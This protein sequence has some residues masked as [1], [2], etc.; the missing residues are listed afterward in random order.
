MT[1]SRQI[2]LTLPHSKLHSQEQILVSTHTWS[3]SRLMIYYYYLPY[4]KILTK[5]GVQSL[6]SYGCFTT[7][8]MRTI[9]HHHLHLVSYKNFLQMN[10]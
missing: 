9:I 8:N 2:Q 5:A 3:L 7:F 4:N 1:K 10:S 6:L